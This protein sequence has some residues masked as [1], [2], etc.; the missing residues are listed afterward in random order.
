M[1]LVE[2]AQHELELSGQTAE[3]PGYA[4][5]LI[6]AIAVF[7]SYGHSGGSAGIAIAQLERLLRFAP[8]SPLTDG[9]DEWIEVDTGVWQNRRC[10]YAFSEDV[11]KTFYVLDGHPGVPG[12]DESV[13]AHPDRGVPLFASKPST[14]A[15]A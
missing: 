10:G 12:T 13:G 8:L 4:A 1:S 15:A 11:G 2:H 7:A 14:A 6:A 5:T 9:A 3:D